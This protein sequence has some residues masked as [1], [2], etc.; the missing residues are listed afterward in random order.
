MG[1]WR[2]LEV[3]RWR[4]HSKRALTTAPRRAKQAFL[5][6]TVTDTTSVTASSPC[7]CPL[8]TVT[9]I[10][11]V[12]SIAFSAMITSHQHHPNPPSQAPP[13]LVHSL[14]HS[15]GSSPGTELHWALVVAMNNTRD[16]SSLGGAYSLVGQSKDK[17]TQRFRKQALE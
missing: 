5:A 1:D 13:S 8:T 16:A 10:I 14:T 15:V 11:I 17:H 4:R 7:H 6:F 9:S 12:T 2:C 3:G